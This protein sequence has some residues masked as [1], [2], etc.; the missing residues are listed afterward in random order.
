MSTQDVKALLQRL[1]AIEERISTVEANQRMI[2]AQMHEVG[3][4]LGRLMES[5]MQHIGGR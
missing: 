2:S 1:D 3:Q 5:W 4:V